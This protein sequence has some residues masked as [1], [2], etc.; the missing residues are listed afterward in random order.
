[1]RACEMRRPEW[2][3]SSCSG[4]EKTRRMD[5]DV[6]RSRMKTSTPTSTS[7]SRRALLT[8]NAVPVTQ[9]EIPEPERSRRV[10]RRLQPIEGDTL[11]DRE[12]HKTAGTPLALIRYT[13]MLG[14]DRCS[15]RFGVLWTLPSQTWRVPSGSSSSD[16]LR[17]R[18]TQ[19]I[20]Y[21]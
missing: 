19:H 11:R 8:T 4:M 2:R 15:G 6:R 9:T 13:E 17:R 10:P 5:G 18:R 14:V 3:A 20:T 16:W 1:M 21:I 12:F 7:T